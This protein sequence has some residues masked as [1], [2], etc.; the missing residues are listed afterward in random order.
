MEKWKRFERLTAALHATKVRGAIVKLDDHINGY[1]IDVSIR[2]EAGPYK[3]L[4]II[5]CKNRRRRV[6]RSDVGALIL[7]MEATGANRGTMVS[8]IGFQSGA[9]KVAA[10]KGIDLY[11]LAEVQEGWER[12]VLKDMPT[13]FVRIWRVG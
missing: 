8:P 12:N 6:S 5:E 10:A 2:I 9:K 4:H 1:Q 3:Y 11:T 7:T 13:P